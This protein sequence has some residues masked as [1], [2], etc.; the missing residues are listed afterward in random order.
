MLWTIDLEKDRSSFPS[1]FKEDEFDFETK[2]IKID[3]EFS[4]VFSY[5]KST[6]MKKINENEFIIGIGIVD[7]IGDFI[8]DEKSEEKKFLPLNVTLNQKDALEMADFINKFKNSIER[9]GK[10]GYEI[11]FDETGWDPII[12]YPNISIYSH[13]WEESD[14]PE[15][16]RDLKSHIV[17]SRIRNSLPENNIIKKNIH[18]IIDF[19]NNNKEKIR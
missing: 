14:E 12:T 2:L 5:G 4:C 9:F 16:Q 15:Y 18:I 11:A 3:E 6:Y 7:K 17:K 19:I 8:L 13:D 1:K 10:N